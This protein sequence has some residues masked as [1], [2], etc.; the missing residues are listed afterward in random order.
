M[1]HSDTTHDKFVQPPPDDTNKELEE[2]TDEVD[3]EADKKKAKKLK[4]PRQPVTE[5]PRKPW[6]DPD[7]YP[8]DIHYFH[9]NLW[10]PTSPN[11]AATSPLNLTA[12]Y[13]NK[14]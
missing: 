4:I 12:R 13:I 14:F 6:R 8:K 3:G 7:K 11:S 10:S 2:I 5:G 1:N 9:S